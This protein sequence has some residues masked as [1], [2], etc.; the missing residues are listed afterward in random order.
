MGC[1]MPKLDMDAHM[2]RSMAGMQM[3]P[4]PHAGGQQKTARTADGRPY[5]AGPRPPG[6]GGPFGGIASSMASSI[7]AS[8]GNQMEAAA[9]RSLEIA[10]AKFARGPHVG[11]DGLL[12][13]PFIDAMWG[14]TPAYTEFIRDSLNP[15]EY[16]GVIVPIN[17]RIRAAAIANEVA[18]AQGETL[19]G[20][21]NQLAAGAD[22]LGGM[23]QAGMNAAAKM[24]KA[25][26]VRD[27]LMPQV[28]ALLFQANRQMAAANNGVVFNLDKREWQTTS[29]TPPS[30]HT[31]GH[32]STH[33]HVQ[34]N[35]QIRC[36]RSIEKLAALGSGALGIGV[37]GGLAGNTTMVGSTGEIEGNLTGCVMPPAKVEQ[38][39]PTNPAYG[40]QQAQANAAGGPGP[41]GP[42]PAAAGGA[43]PVP[44]PRRRA[45]PPAPNA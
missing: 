7:M 21:G 45:A 44:V 3:Q 5:V 10:K 17:E 8:V 14:F 16:W 35:I 6:F 37:Q 38:A 39:M 22:G 23:M 36:K 43:P 33:N 34:Y 41:A 29:Y 12:T 24:Q 4:N 2:Q 31:P 40:L 15:E 11:P 28:Q 26:A 30:G 20:I 13:V 25:N 27:A 19:S 1:C 42:G 9:K 32:H 18:N